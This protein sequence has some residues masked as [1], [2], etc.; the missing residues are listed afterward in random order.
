MRYYNFISNGSD[1]STQLSNKPYYL[2]STMLAP[3]LAFDLSLMAWCHCFPFAFCDIC[4][5]SLPSSNL[6]QG[7]RFYGLLLLPSVNLGYWLSL[8]LLL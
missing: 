6:E 4:L 1:F 7:D 5:P 8:L 2:H 3:D